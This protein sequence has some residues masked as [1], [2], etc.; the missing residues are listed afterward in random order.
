MTTSLVAADV[1][2]C[3]LHI[4]TTSLSLEKDCLLMSTLCTP[5]PGSWQRRIRTQVLDKKCLLAWRMCDLIPVDALVLS[6]LLIIT[7][8]ASVHQIPGADIRVGSILS[9]IQQ[10]VALGAVEE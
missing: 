3:H 9:G 6:S 2:Q 7:V 10:I 4:R 8:P 1:V 5:H